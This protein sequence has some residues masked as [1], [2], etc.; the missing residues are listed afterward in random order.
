VVL[1]LAL[2]AGACL[3]FRK[4]VMMVPVVRFVDVGAPG[5]T[6]A[7]V[8]RVTVDD[9][10]RYVL[11]LK[12]DGFEATFDSAEVQIP[13]GARL[14]FDLGANFGAGGD[15]AVTFEVRA[16][17]APGCE[18]VFSERVDFA[19]PGTPAWL[20]R[21]V[22]LERFAGSSRRFVFHSLTT[23]PAARALWGNPTVL[24]PAARPRDARNIILIS[25]DTLRADHLGSYGYGRGTATTTTA[26]HM[27]MFTALPPS[28]HGVGLTNVTPLPAWMATVPELLRAQAFTTGA[29]TE[30]GWVTFALGF[31]RGFDTYQENKGSDV[32]HPSG[33]VDVTFGAA[34]EWLRRYRDRRF[35]L[36]LHT[37]QV[38]FPYVPPPE[39]AP[40]FADQVPADAPP[41]VRDAADY[42]REIRFTDDTL[43]DLFATMRELHLDEDTVV[44][45][46][47]DH[48]E[49]FGEHGCFF[50][51]D[52]LYDEVTHVPLMIWG[53]G[54]P[55]GVRVPQPVGLID[56][57]PTILD[58]GGVR[59]PAQAMGESLVQALSSGRARAGRH[60]FTESWAAKPCMPDYQQPGF[61]VREGT[62]KLA[63][64]RRSGVFSYELYDLA[65]DPLERTNRYAADAADTRALQT[66]VDTY[67]NDC[68]ARAQALRGAAGATSEPVEAAPLDERQRQKLRALGYAD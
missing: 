14:E 64:Y 24:A 57:M 2:G 30:D 48:G 28:V 20:S 4:P 50:H 68:N 53:A 41:A 65:S 1:F 34:K 35:F 16:C 21:S 18:G 63:R 54:I 49:A 9:Q 25:L 46:T 58:L 39:Y 36:F 13:P 31:G 29:I 5:S 33:Q 67:V 52:Q 15:R 59:I 11:P 17:G 23:T 37:Y 8:R 40:M 62:R 27:T 3:W 56:V 6:G 7:G 43:R 61:V 42:D 51:G 26:S 44:V 47:A 38:H 55:A 19:S 10:T 32:M 12:Q 45:L 60:L 22:A 66:A